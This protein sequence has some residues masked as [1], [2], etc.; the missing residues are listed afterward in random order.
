MVVARS[1]G[2]L[3]ESGIHVVQRIFGA[4]ARRLSVALQLEVE[5]ASAVEFA[6][7]D[8]LP[9]WS[10]SL[11]PSSQP[12]VGAFVRRR[13]LVEPLRTCDASFLL[14]QEQRRE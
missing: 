7:S 5:A 13:L 8:S 11:R 14:V 1:G 4:V 6:S 12:I 2:L 9:S 3:P 10:F